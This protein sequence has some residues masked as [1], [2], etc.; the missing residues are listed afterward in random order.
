MEKAAAGLVRVRDGTLGALRDSDNDDA[1]VA[2]L[3]EG[4]SKVRAL[5][6]IPSAEGLEN[7]APG[8]VRDKCADSGTCNAG[9]ETKRGCIPLK[10]LS[11]L[12]V[13]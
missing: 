12:S 10:V 8:W 3:L 2:G 11:V 4:G 13:V 6:R 7:D 1:V 9:E 5:G